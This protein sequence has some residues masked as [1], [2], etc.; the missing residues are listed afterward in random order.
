MKEE[1]ENWKKEFLPDEYSKCE[2]Y[3][4]ADMIMFATYYHKKKLTLMNS[5]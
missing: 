5:N 4:N 1:L 2:E 3:D